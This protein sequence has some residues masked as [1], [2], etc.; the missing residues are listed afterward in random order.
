MSTLRSFSLFAVAI[1][2]SA[3]AGGGGVNPGSSP[4][5][6]A[7]ANMNLGAGYLQQGNTA[8]AIERLQRALAQDP[9]LVDAHSTIALAY[10]QA[11]S[12]EEAETHYLRATQ[13]DPENSG[14]A[15]AYAVFLCSRQNRWADAEPYFRRA[16]ADA[17]YATPEVAL[18][19]AGVCARSAGDDAGAEES[20]RAAL[21]R[22]PVY[23]DALLNMIELSYQAE[24]YLQARAFVQRYL[25]IRP[26]T[27]AVLWTCFNVER[28]LDNMPGA[29]RCAT[30]LRSGFQGSA[31][32]AQLEEQQRGNGR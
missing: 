7:V 31:E 5:E 3:C 16:A 28:E 18:T 20:F 21:A 15:N 13:L 30:Q 9:R 29:E 8:L 14:A 1:V 17:D 10:D 32:L 19:N 24:N 4:E 12:L 25:A 11:G 22:N 27:A 6:A 2:V 23:P 26:A